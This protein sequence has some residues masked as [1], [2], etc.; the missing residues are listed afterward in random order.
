MKREKT[1]YVCQNC[2][3]V[4]L[5]WLGRCP[6]CGEWNSLVEEVRQET[7][8]ATS[9]K[10]I[11]PVPLPQI[12]TEKQERAATGL[13]ELDRVLGGGL[14]RGSLVLVGGDPGIGKSTLL[15]QAAGY[16]AQKG[17]VL[18]ISAEESLSQLR[19]R[20]ERLG[21]EGPQVLAAAENCLED[22]LTAV[23]AG[24]DWQAVIIDSIQTVHSRE[25]TSAPGSVSQV[26]HCT[27]LL[28]DLAKGREIAT[29]IVGH[30]TKE[31]ALAGPR[32]LEHM[33]DTVLYFEGERHQNYRLLRAVKNRFGS[34]NE[35]GLFEMTGSGLIDVSN[36]SGLLL[37][38][39]PVGEPGSVVVVAMEGSR[40][41]L[42]EIQALISPGNLANPRR[43]T[44]GLDYQRVAL[45][46]AV[47]EKRLGMQLSHMDAF[48][49]VAGGLKLTEPAVDLG[50]AVALASS[51]RERSVDPEM[52]I[53]GE[54][55]LTG[56]V[57]RVNQMEKRL[58]EAARIG[59]KRAVVPSGQKPEGPAELE[60]IEVGTVAEALDWSLG[61]MGR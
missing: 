50:V 20:A 16:L 56:E 47:L 9:G 54:V 7:R 60:I 55:G 48:V 29:L 8:T 40:P 32:V 13:A 51:W 6:G 5:R 34:T 23:D 2:G 46:L 49:N 33:V 41:I 57:R 39:R 17:P 26:R 43:M 11:I 10:K 45:L 35:L 53:I 3:Q 30:V 28:L 12:K 4:E 36:P 38:Q 42:V 52:V 61:G 15:L 27:G 59:F 37:A 19:M 1:R 25:I 44:S 58:Q 31:G 24:Q 21:V 14:V 18:Y 22:I